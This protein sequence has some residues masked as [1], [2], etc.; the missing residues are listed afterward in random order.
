MVVSENAVITLGKLALLHTQDAAQAGKFLSMLP[1]S[2]AEEAQ[3]AHE[4]LFN[5][6]LASNGLLSGACKPAVIKA[7]SAIRDAHAQDGELLTEEGVE[8][9]NKVIAGMGI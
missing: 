3:E 9:M 1:L 4:F 6:I 8:Q 2:S 5:Q 7:V